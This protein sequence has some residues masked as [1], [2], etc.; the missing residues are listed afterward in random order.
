[1]S[2]APLIH[3]ESV[4]IEDTAGTNNEQYRKWVSY[5]VISEMKRSNS[6]LLLALIKDIG[7]DPELAKNIE[8]AMEWRRK[9]KIQSAEF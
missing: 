9:V 7:T 2:L 6:A 4:T 5:R 1:M 8:T 3:K